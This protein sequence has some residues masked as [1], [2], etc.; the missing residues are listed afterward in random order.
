MVGDGGPDP[1][2]VATT[3]GARPNPTHRRLVEILAPEIMLDATTTITA[4]NHPPSSHDR[5]RRF[6]MISALP[7]P[8]LA[9]MAPRL[10]CE[11]V[12]VPVHARLIRLCALA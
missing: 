2:I 11:I 12:R 6:T 3:M 5:E 4:A 10:T 7:E 9:W 8:Y 1:I